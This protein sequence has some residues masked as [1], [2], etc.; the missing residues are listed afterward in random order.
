MCPTLP[1]TLKRTTNSECPNACPCLF[2]ISLRLEGTTV[3]SFRL[4]QLGEVETRSPLLVS[5]H[6]QQLFAIPGKL[7]DKHRSEPICLRLVRLEGEA[8]LARW[9][10]PYFQLRGAPIVALVLSF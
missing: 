2:R 4:G 1:Q 5:S 6:S 10:L 8:L 7:H 9:H 3:I